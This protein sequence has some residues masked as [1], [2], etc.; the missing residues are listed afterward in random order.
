MEHGGD[1]V[2]DAAVDLEDARAVGGELDLGVQAA[3]LDTECGDGLRRQVERDLLL[4]W[5]ERRRH[6]ESRLPELLGR[7]EAPGDRDVVG[8]PAGHDAL[9]RDVVRERASRPARVVGQVFLE[10]HLA[11]VD[12]QALDQG[13]DVIAITREH[14]VVTARGRARFEHCRPRDVV[15]HRRERIGDR[16]TFERPVP[17]Y[18]QPGLSQRVALLE[19]VGEPPGH[20]GCDERQVQRLGE[21]GDLDHPGVVVGDDAVRP[22]RSDLSGGGVGGQPADVDD[23]PEMAHEPG[24][25]VHLGPSTVDEPHE[26]A[27]PARGFGEVDEGYRGDGP[28][29]VG[30]GDQPAPGGSAVPAASVGRHGRQ[31]TG[32]RADVVRRSCIPAPD[33]M[34]PAPGLRPAFRRG[35]HAGAAHG[36][37]DRPRLC[38]DEDRT[39]SDPSRSR[40]RHLIDR[41]GLAGHVLCR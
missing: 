21:G 9:H 35:P 26:V 14:C 25:L 31:R 23:G 18:L 24:Q 5:V 15:G 8:A 38:R 40:L 3:E 12:A 10:H 11:G 4:A 7:R 29:T 2:P 33:P 1:A 17:R 20:R 36:S 22:V 16:W 39:A 37:A 28:R 27:D 30:H 34:A 13:T 41:S 32:R 19:L 6:E